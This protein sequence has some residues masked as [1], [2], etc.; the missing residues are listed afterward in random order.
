MKWYGRAEY[1][2]EKCLERNCIIIFFFSGGA[3]MYR[4]LEKNILNLVQ[5]MKE[6]VCLA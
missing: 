2:L 6:T 1:C 5:E 4:W 3:I